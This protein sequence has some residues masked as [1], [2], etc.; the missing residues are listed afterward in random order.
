M[1]AG[2]LQRGR[3]VIPERG[4]HIESGG[5]PSSPATGAIVSITC[6]RPLIV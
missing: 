3:D 1:I 2:F 6:R 5:D 4:R